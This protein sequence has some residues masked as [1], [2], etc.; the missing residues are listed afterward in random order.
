MKRIIFFAAVAF[1]AIAAVVS[2]KLAGS[3]A[4]AEPADKVFISKDFPVSDFIELEVDVPAD[5]KYETG[6]PYC[7]IEGSSGIIDKLDVKITGN[8]LK[9]S[10]SRKFRNIKKLD[11]VLSSSTLVKL[12]LN[13]TA[14]FE[15]KRGFETE[16]FKSVCNGAADISIDNLIAEDVRININ[17]AGDIGLENLSAR[18]TDVQI[19]GA[20]EVSLSGSSKDVK[21]VI[22]GAGNID[23][24]ELRYDTISA[25]TNGVGRIER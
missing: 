25:S 18:K 23:V 15:C 11:I 1:V 10:T 14:E 4:N 17:G 19:N 16:S 20:G 24:K 5:I 6:E 3:V 21:A 9:I 12:S 7:H 22:N 8:S 2:G 13:G